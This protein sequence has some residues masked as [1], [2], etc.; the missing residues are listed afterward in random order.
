MC[1]PSNRSRRSSESSRSSTLFLSTTSLVPRSASSSAESVHFPSSKPKTSLLLGF[2]P[3]YLPSA[4]DKDIHAAW[5]F[6]LP[7]FLLPRTRTSLLLG[8]SCFLPSLS[9]GQEH[10]CCLGFPASYLP[11]AEDKDIPAAWAFLLPTFLPSLSR[12]HPCCLGFPPSYLPPAEDKDIPALGRSCFLPSSCRGQGHPCCLGFPASYLP[13][14]EDKDIP[15]AWAFLLPTFLEP[16]T[17]TSL[18]LGLSCFLPS[19][20]RGQGHPCCLGFHASYLPTFLEPRTSLLLG[21][22]SLLPSSCRGQGH[23]CSWAFLLPTFLQPR[24]RTSLLLGFP[25]SY[26]PPAEDKDIPAGLGFPASYLPPAEDKDIPALGL[27][28]FLASSSRG[29]PCCLGFPPSYLP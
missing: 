6:L 26:L 13:P 23:P 24:T 21:L 15:A 25:A 20:C 28:C 8:L 27:S 1:V 3:S 4:E 22:P 5:A 17:R 14:A 12:G 18:L 10:P 29:H 7:T 16:R 9:R 11:P 2:P 19:S